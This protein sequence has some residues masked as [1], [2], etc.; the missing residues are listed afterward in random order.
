[1]GHSRWKMFFAAFYFLTHFDLNIGRYDRE[2]TRS[3]KNL[4]TQIVKK[5]KDTNVWC[6]IQILPKEKVVYNWILHIN[7]QVLY[8]FC[9][10]CHTM[11]SWKF[12]EHT[13]V[14][15]F[16][17]LESPIDRMLCFKFLWQ[18]FMLVGVYCGILILICFNTSSY[19]SVPTSMAYRKSIWL[20]FSY[21][22]S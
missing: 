4:I 18:T 11:N 22:T 14:N 3:F 9:F 7:E 21:G 2:S 8:T 15:S 13:F 16:I 6:I 19:K 1:M 12:F 5:D 17:R 20:N 10:K